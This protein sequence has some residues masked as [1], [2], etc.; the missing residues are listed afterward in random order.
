[1]LTN[2]VGRVLGV[3]GLASVFAMSQACDPNSEDV[4]VRTQQGLA[5]KGAT[6]GKGNGPVPPDGYVVKWTQCKYYVEGDL[7]LR[8]NSRVV[9]AAA[10]GT[11]PI[12]RVEP[13]PGGE[14]NRRRIRADKP[15]GKPLKGGVAFD[16]STKR[17]VTVYKIGQIINVKHNDGSVSQWVVST[18]DLGQPARL[19]DGRLAYQDTC[20][21]NPKLM[22]R[23]TAGRVADGTELA[24]ICVVEDLNQ[25][26]NA[27]SAIYGWTPIYNWADGKVG[28]KNDPF[29][30]PHPD[31]AAWDGASMGAN[32]YSGYGAAMNDINGNERDYYGDYY[33]GEGWCHYIVQSGYEVPGAKR[34]ASKSLPAPGSVNT[35]S[36]V[37]WR[38]VNP[39][40][41]I[42]NSEEPVG[43]PSGDPIEEDPPATDATIADADTMPPA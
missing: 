3:V 9:K 34:P 42:A 33:I 14:D 24:N 2:K 8:N 7:K 21:R 4:N 41:D 31:N 20:F 12:M 36:L 13:V 1:M 27:L 10:D 23:D 19:K 11:I 29:A 40:L 6:G 38:P 15:G 43:Q 5:A 39:N 37:A 35:N 18:W 25:E 17:E 32:W 26:W 30:H 16:A 22:G 28:M